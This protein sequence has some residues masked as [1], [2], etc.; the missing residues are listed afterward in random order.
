MQVLGFDVHRYLLLRSENDVSGC[1][2]V[3][4][5]RYWG[6]ALGTCFRKLCPLSESTSLLGPTRLLLDYMLHRWDSRILCSLPL[7]WPLPSPHLKFCWHVQ[8]DVPGV[9]SEALSADECAWSWDWGVHTH[10]WEVHCGIAWSWEWEK[11]GGTSH[12]NIRRGFDY[13]GV[14]EMSQR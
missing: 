8:S 3:P 12:A 1:S 6:P 13:P 14:R 10:A 4:R 9:A 7:G 2:T 11:N 5:P